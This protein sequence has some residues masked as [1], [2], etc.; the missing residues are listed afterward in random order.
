MPHPILEQ[1]EVSDF[2]KKRKL[3]RQLHTKQRSS[4]TGNIGHAQR[5][6]CMSI[7]FTAW[8]QRRR[9]I[10]PKADRIL[11]LVKAA[12][13]YRMTRRQIGHAVD[14]DRDVLD[15]LLNGLVSAGMLMSS[16]DARGPV[17]WATG[18]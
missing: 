1:A 16:R 12:G 9:S 2:A 11:P 18:V 5:K 8:E 10:S 3:C 4:D 6:Y 15:Q 17:Y 7:S 13:A 14:L